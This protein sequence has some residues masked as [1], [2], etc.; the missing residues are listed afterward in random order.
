[1][2]ATTAVSLPPDAQARLE[3]LANNGQKSREDDDS[4]DGASSDISAFSEQG[5]NKGFL[6]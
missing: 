6:G 3:M 2:S 5:K 1:M 4:R